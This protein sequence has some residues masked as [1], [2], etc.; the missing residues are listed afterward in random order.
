MFSQLNIKNVPLNNGQERNDAR[1]WFNPLFF[2]GKSTARQAK[3]H[4]MILWPPKLSLGLFPQ[5]SCTDILHHPTMKLL[6]KLLL[7]PL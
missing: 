2:A 6:D 7:P 1:F 4:V 3:G 5:R